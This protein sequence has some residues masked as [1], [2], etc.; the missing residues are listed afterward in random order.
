M[1]LPGAVSVSFDPGK[2]LDALSSTPADEV[3]SPQSMYYAAF[4][5]LH[6][7]FAEVWEAAFSRI[8]VFVDDLDRCL[9]ASA[10]T[11]IESMKLFFDLPGF[12]FVVGMDKRVV[13]RAV[14]VKFREQTVTAAATDTEVEELEGEYMK[15]IVQVPYAVPA[16]SPAH[17]VELL[18]W[19]EEHGGLGDAQRLDLR[20]RVRRFL[21]YVA[22]EGRINPREV[23][24][25]AQR[26]HLG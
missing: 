13:E 25:L 3:G 14:R 22:V 20:H 26:G 2:A 18:G 19:I 9:P 11:V 23:K 17:L 16:M 10:L 6:T 4:T 15:K 5:E 7:A 24:R 8:V 21:R 12:V 1:G